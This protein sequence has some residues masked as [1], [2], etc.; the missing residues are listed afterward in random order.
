M[1]Y[2][3]LREFADSWGLVI[4]TAVFLSLIGWAF[5]PRNREANRR[6]A[7]SIFEDENDN[8]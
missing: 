8:G 2:H 3:F 1:N 6:A 4:M 5:L 7:Q